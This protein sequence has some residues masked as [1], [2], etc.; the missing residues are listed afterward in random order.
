MKI[1][2]NIEYLITNNKIKVC[3]NIIGTLLFILCYVIVYRSYNDLFLFGLSHNAI[4]FIVLFCFFASLIVVSIPIKFIILG[5]LPATM[6]FF[7]LWN[8]ISGVYYNKTIKNWNTAKGV[9]KSHHVGKVSNKIYRLFIVYQYEV[10]NKKYSNNRFD[11]EKTFC[12]FKTEIKAHNFC[13]K[14]TEVLVHYSPDNARESILSARI[15]WTLI[16]GNLVGVLVFGY[17]SFY[18]INFGMIKRN[19]AQKAKQKEEI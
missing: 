6:A 2:E 9:I 15:S 5:M 14:G 18:F 16:A 17:I 1:M 7:A 10:N 11:F 19:H 4:C 12:D 8:T 13:P 3:A